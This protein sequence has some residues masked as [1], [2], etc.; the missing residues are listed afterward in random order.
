MIRKFRQRAKNL[1]DTTLV[2]FGE[3]KPSPKLHNNLDKVFNKLPL[4]GEIN[5]LTCKFA[6]KT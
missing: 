3:L 1:L 5:N 2:T 6:T 4:M